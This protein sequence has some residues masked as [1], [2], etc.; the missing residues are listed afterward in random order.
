MRYLIGILAGIV[1]A[2][3]ATAAAAPCHEDQPCWV[4]SK[5]GNKQRGVYVDGKLYVVMPCTYANLAHAH[6]LDKTNVKLR[7]DVWAHWVCD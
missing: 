1:L 4:W 3:P 5:M 7:G 2:F 6:R